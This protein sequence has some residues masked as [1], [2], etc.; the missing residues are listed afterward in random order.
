MK[1]LIYYLLILA[2]IITQFP[3]QAATQDQVSRQQTTVEATIKEI[4]ELDKQI[5]TLEQQI[6]DLN[7]KIEQTSKD[8]LKAQEDVKELTEL[9]NNRVRVA[10]VYGT[11]G[12]M[13]YLFSGE[14]P[15]DFITHY[16]VAKDILYADQESLDQ[17][18]AKQKEI[19]TLQNN[20]ISQRDLLVNTKNQAEA[21][22]NQKN[23]ALSS[24]Q[25]VLQTL[26]SSLQD[27]GNTSATTNTQTTPTITIT[28][29]MLAGLSTTQSVPL[30]YSTPQGNNATALSAAEQQEL[31][32]SG[33][34]SAASVS[35]RWLD[36]GSSTVV[37][38]GSAVMSSNEGVTSA[39]GISSSVG[40]SNNP[41]VLEIPNTNGTITQIPRSGFPTSFFW[42]LDS[43]SPGAFTIT[44]L[45]GNRESPGGIGST[46]HGGIDIG[47]AY[48]T[49]IIAA[50]SGTVEIASVYGGYGNAVMINHGN[51]LRTLYGHMSSIAV[52]QGQTV[53]AGQVIG[54]VGSTGWST[55]PHLHFEVRYTDNAG[56]ESKLNGLSL[57]GQD[58]LNVL[59]YSL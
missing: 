37:N 44:S 24:N 4:A 21:L 49:P 43:S 26:K 13:D 17:L 53:Q 23:Q 11:G 34:A 40:Y 6:I 30:I 31:D 8:L 55:G 20:Q 1:K 16:D 50:A 27:S 38:N 9:T 22:K 46:D 33:Q 14:K 59:S 39:Q 7:N 58:I 15:S 45:V 25:A 48:G 41:Y 36:N 18:E 19:E 3:I 57:Y 2:L 29:E 42:P 35:P 10:Y 54:L 28:P 52:S 32:A 56:N 51:G 47:A 12:Y 5:N